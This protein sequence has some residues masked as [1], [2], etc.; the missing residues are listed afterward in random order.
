MARGVYGL[1]AVYAFQF[2]CDC[3]HGLAFLMFSDLCCNPKQIECFYGAV[4][5]A[6]CGVCVSFPEVVRVVL[7]FKN[8]H[9]VVSFLD[10]AVSVGENVAGGLLA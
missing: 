3:V 8:V 10:L 6:G 1:H 9:C 2:D 4:I 7:N 5:V